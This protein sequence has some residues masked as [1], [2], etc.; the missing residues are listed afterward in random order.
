VKQL[1]ILVL[2]LLFPLTLTA[3]EDVEQLLQLVDYVGVDY[4]E[5]VKDGVVINPAEYGEMQDFAAAIQSQAGQL[6]T[7][8]A[9][10]QLQAQADKLISLVA[11]RVEPPIVSALTASMRL[12]IINGFN[13]I[14]VPRRTPDLQL[15]KR[16]YADNCVSCH[17]VSGQGDGPLAKSLDPAPTDF[18]D[19]ERY[20]QRTL[21]GLYNTITYGVEGT[22]MNPFS[23]LSGH[24]RWSLAFYTG[25]LATRSVEQQAGNGLW[26]A[27]GEASPLA[28]LDALTTLTPAQVQQEAGE[29]GLA[30]VA[31][32]RTQPGVLFT[33]QESPLAY[34]Q[35][36]LQESLSLAQ[37]G[38]SEQAYKVAVDAYLEGFELAE[39]TLN[40]VDAELRLSIE[41]AMTAYRTMVR[42]A[43]PIPALETH[44]EHTL[45]LLKQ[46]QTR[47]DS[48]TLSGEAAFTGAF[49][50]L[51]REG[52]EALLVLAALGA[53]LIKTGRRDGLPYLY[54][55][56]ILALIM[57]GLTWLAS[58]T[59]I[60][61]S[62]A[63]RELTEGFAA[64]FAATVLFY[65]G[66]WLHG[67]TSAIQWKRFIEGNIQK[68]LSKGTLWGLATLSFIAVY[69]EMFE[70]VL[71]Y[72]A[73]WIQADQNGHS[74]ILSGLV[75]ASLLLFVLGWLILR[76][77]TRLPLRQFF[78]V[79][80]LFMFLLAMI[81]AGKGIAALQEAGKMTLSPVD[82]PRFDLLGIY[83][84]LEGLAV[85]AVMVMLALFLLFGSRLFPRP[86]VAKSK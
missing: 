2:A 44:A 79:T 48:T 67:K 61:I 7:S 45:A 14:A 13:I 11:D 60:D 65:V 56:L 71:F 43:A 6:P 62:G 41:E 82:F 80:G 73:L 70:T 36:R 42:T 52:L 47:L 77:S 83:P 53:F 9:A 12:Q 29:D 27:A 59:I 16:L 19:R 58:T 64:L 75:L 85:Q 37:A 8:G 33:Q 84:N 21:Y 10:Q 18:R 20:L 78:A 54:G 40:T 74:M 81:F 49:I 66:F 17:G 32:L 50:I 39:N 31:F 63:Q 4:E 46:A 38:E 69:R 3:G 51:L 25:Q 23:G 5:A 24:E 22:G 26:Q 57:G 28:Q 34:S 35:R 55:G 30:L 86:A 15:A 76:Y 72:Q 1:I 68:A